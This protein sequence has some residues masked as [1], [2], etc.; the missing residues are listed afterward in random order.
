M[1]AV[2]IAGDPG[3]M[4]ALLALFQAGNMAGIMRNACNGVFRVSMAFF[5]V[6]CIGYAIVA[7]AQCKRVKCLFALLLQLYKLIAGISALLYIHA[8]LLTIPK[9]RIYKHCAI[10]PNNTMLHFATKTGHSS[11]PTR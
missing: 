8:V 9:N 7:T 3:A 10:P 1:Q 5:N 6:Q 11:D 4:L 2:A